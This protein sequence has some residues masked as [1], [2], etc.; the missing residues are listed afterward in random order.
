MSDDELAVQ[1]RITS[2]VPV[3]ESDTDCGLPL[4]LSVRVREAEPA[5]LAVGVNEITIVQVLPA[6]TEE[7]QVLFSTKSDGSAPVKAILVM[8]IAVPPVLSR[9]TD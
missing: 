2:C 3:P 6:A 5:P 8:V 1:V 7:P 9:V 4:A